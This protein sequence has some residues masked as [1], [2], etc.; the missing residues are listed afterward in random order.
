MKRRFIFDALSG[1]FVLRMQADSWRLRGYATFS[2][3]ASS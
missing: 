2:E 3:D 1:C